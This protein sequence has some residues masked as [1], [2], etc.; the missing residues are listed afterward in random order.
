MTRA[1]TT[2]PEL[3]FVLPFKV[4]HLTVLS[5]ESGIPLFTHAWVK[6]EVRID[7]AL[8]TGM[9]QG[10]T[11]FLNEAINKGNVRQIELDQ[12]V[13]L[14]R[15]SDEYPVACVLVAN[16]STRLLRQS[17][18][19]FATRFFAE[20]APYFTHISATSLDNFQNASHLI[21][22]TMPFIPEYT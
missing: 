15:R 22:E 18:D 4:S 2:C 19:A 21:S 17:L 3:A 7:D 6:S 11:G 20:F 12:G 5:T 1:F 9:L 8:F 10:I 16:K 13:L 14:I